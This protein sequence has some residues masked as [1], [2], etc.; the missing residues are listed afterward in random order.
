VPVDERPVVGVDNDFEVR[1]FALQLEQEVFDAFAARRKKT[2]RG[3]PEG[4]GD[5][6]VGDGLPISLPCSV[7]ITMAENK[8]KM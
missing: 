4:S 6:P 1:K 3:S 5:H 2:I 7:K 8:L